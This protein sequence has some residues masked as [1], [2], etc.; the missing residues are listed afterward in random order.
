MDLVFREMA[1]GDCKRVAEIENE[2]FSD[3]WTEQ[4]FRTAL[5]RSDVLAYICCSNEN[6]IAYIIL[7]LESNN[8]RIMNIAVQQDYRRKGVGL[9]C[10]HYIEECA[11][12]K[13]SN[14]I[15]LEVQETNLPV[16]LLCRKAGYKA[17]RILRNHYPSVNEDGYLMSKILKE[18]VP[19]KQISH[20]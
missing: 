11:R 3:P 2:S 9:A 16:Q 19:A 12:K 18:K 8:I 7:Q 5:N 15:Y 4:G 10:F 14:K 17:V 6:I 13:D 20:E 1:W